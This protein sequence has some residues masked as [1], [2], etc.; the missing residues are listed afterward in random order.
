VL[1]FDVFDGAGVPIDFLGQP[2]PTLT[3]AADIALRTGALMIPFFG[4][5]RGD[6]FACVFDTPIPHSDPEEMMRAATRALEQRIAEDPGQWFWIHRRWKPKRQAKT[7][8][9]RAAATMG[10]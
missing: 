9:K 7:Q 6:G 1:L 8:R 2:A 4:L 3:S 5:R 10:P